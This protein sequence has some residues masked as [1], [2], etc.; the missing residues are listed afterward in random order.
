MFKKHK[1][2]MKKSISTKKKWISTDAWRGYEQPVNAVAGANDTGN[3]SDSPCPSSISLKEIDEARQ[4]LKQ[5]KIVSKTIITRSSNVFCAHRYL[6]THPENKEKAK[7][8]LKPLL[9]QTR[10]FYIV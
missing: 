5:N 10:L 6:L 4:I 8:L 1:N 9:D 7:D 3:W 2:K